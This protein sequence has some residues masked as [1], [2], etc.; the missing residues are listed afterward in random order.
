[1]I[2]GVPSEIRTEYLSNMSLQYYRCAILLDDRFSWKNKQIEV[3]REAW[4]C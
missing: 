4:K 3:R 1:M 2:A